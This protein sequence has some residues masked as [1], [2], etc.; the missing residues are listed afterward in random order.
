M[1]YKKRGL[2]FTLQFDM[3]NDADP[4]NLNNFKAL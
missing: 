1:N 2:I 4:E 3:T